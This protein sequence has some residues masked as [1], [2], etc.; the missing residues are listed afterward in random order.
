M[1]VHNALNNGSMCYEQKRRCQLRLCLCREIPKNVENVEKK[2]EK[3]VN[4]KWMKQI[5]RND[6]DD[7]SSFT[8]VLKPT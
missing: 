2:C 5:F 4:V 3:S 6:L 8:I 1:S 7:N